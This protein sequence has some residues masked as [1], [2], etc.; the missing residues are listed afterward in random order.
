MFRFEK[1]DIWNEAIRYASEIYSLTQKFPRH[2]LFSLTDQL[3]RC[4][5]SI[6]ANIA[7]GSG[8][9]SNRDFAHYLEISIKSTYESVSHLQIAKEQNYISEEE[10]AFYYEKAELLA[11]RIRAFQHKLKSS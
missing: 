7:E 3:R 2:E 10:R 11:R 1:L 5:G 6:A 8:S 9:S 4:S